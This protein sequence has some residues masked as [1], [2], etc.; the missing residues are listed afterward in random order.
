MFPK[1]RH[2]ILQSQY[3]LEEGDTRRALSLVL[4]DAENWRRVLTFKQDERLKR[5]TQSGQLMD[6]D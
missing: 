4:D 5:S 6:Q 1:L 2:T 3:K